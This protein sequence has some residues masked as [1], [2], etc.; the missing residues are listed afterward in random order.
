MER[1]TNNSAWYEKRAEGQVTRT[2]YLKG[3]GKFRYVRELRK[4]S[5]VVSARRVRLLSSRVEIVF[6]SGTTKSDRRQALIGATYRAK[7]RSMR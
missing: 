2:S 1:L 5:C 3:Q 6:A 4:E 7:E